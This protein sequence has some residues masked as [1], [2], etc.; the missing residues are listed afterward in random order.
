MK[1]ILKDT[2][3]LMLL[4]MSSLGRASP[5][6]NDLP[7]PQWEIARAFL[8][9]AKRLA[10]ETIENTYQ[11]IWDYVPWYDDD[12]VPIDFVFKNKVESCLV[13]LGSDSLRVTEFRCLNIESKKSTKEYQK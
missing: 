3:C 9:G 10:S 7:H 11:V 5:M 13:S 4:S 12:D 1:K 6:P 2:I 8:Q